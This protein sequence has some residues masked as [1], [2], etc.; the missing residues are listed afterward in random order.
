MKE[1][2]RILMTSTIDQVE[3]CTLTDV[4][5]LTLT[6]ALTLF[7]IRFRKA[8]GGSYGNSKER[9]DHHIDRFI[10]HCEVVKPLNRY[11]ARKS[12]SL[13]QGYNSLYV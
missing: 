11:V 5:P 13:I 1:G 6:K 2:L 12:S 3:T 9:R 7:Y 8:C 10:E 4:A